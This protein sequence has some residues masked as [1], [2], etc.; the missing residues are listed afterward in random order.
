MMKYCKDC[1][2]LVTDV[3][4]ERECHAPQNLKTIV[5]LTNDLYTKPKYPPYSL[6]HINGFLNLY[7][8]FCGKEGRWFEQKE[9][10]E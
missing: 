1:K 7:F 4:K 6:R 9:E 10:K 8:K 2:F 3:W 5:D